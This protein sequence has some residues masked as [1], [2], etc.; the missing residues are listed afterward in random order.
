[1]V[2]QD[3]QL[4]KNDTEEHREPQ[5]YYWDTSE[6]LNIKVIEI[7]INRPS[8]TK[9]QSATRLAPLSQTSTPTP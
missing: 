8:S 5:E 6:Y 4:A 7:M 9:R 1:M 2:N 3:L